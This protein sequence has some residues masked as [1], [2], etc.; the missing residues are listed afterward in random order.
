MVTS[1]SQRYIGISSGNSSHEGIGI[2]VIDMQDHYLK[3]V[4]EQDRD[5]L[6]EAQDRLFD[7]AD[8]H[9]YPVM[10]VGYEGAGEISDRTLRGSRRILRRRSIKKTKDS[11]FYSTNLKSRLNEWGVTRP[12]LT[13]L[14][15]PI[16]VFETAKDARKNGFSPITSPWLMEA[17]LFERKDV[18]KTSHWYQMFTEYHPRA[19]TVYE[20]LEQKPRVFS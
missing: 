1:T 12:L 5:W 20:M 14:N 3:N 16:C 13:G 2:V 19:E 4:N 9:D 6:F 7:I 11:A 8:K 18:H 15:G 17:E 10:L